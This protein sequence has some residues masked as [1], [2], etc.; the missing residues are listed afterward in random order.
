MKS[1]AW[2]GCL[3]ILLMALSSC[4]PGPNTVEKTADEQGRVAG[5]WRGLWHGLISPVT[6]IISI[7]TKDVRI[8]EVHNNGSW[9]NFGFVLGA[10]LFLQG[11]I[12]GSR[13][14]RKRRRG[15]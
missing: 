2:L 7:F 10:G 5:F 3:L 15:F 8:Y 11:G 9:Y 1:I 12:L 14:A 13:K 6:F 4:A